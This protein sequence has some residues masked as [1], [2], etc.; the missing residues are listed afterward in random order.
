MD[1]LN[2]E[3]MK[4]K[5]ELL[6]LKELHAAARTDKQRDEVDRKMKVLADQNPDAF[7]AAMIELARGSADQAE[8]LALREQ[9]SDILPVVSVSYIA[10][11]Y[12]GKTR[13]WLYQR[14]NGSI[15]NGKPARLSDDERKTLDGALK[16][17][18]HKLTTTHVF[19]SV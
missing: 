16:D 2:S 17:I 15:V 19:P 11:T 1:A 12:F 10:K 6:K 14:I 13:Q 8:E 18:G 9:L 3:E 7:A 5:N 4:M